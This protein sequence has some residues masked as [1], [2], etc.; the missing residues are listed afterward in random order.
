MPKGYKL[1]KPKLSEISSTES[2]SYV[3]TP[4]YCINWSADKDNKIEVIKAQTGKTVNGNVS[5]LAKVS[6][7]QRYTHLM[8]I[9]PNANELFHVVGGNYYETKCAARKYQVKF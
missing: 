6:F 9:L 4:D 5:Q 7:F 8:D 3:N 1:N 2:R